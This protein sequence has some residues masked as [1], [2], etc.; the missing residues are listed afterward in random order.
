MC[1]PD[2]RVV[3][4]EKGSQK[5]DLRTLYASFALLAAGLLV[6]SQ[7]KAFHWDEGFHILAARLINLGKRPYLDFFFPQT[8]LNAYWNAAWM[9]IF[10]QSWHVVHAVAALATIGSVILIAQYLFVLFPDRKWKPIVAFAALA[11]FGLN[12]LVWEFGAISQAYPLCLLLT[13]AAFRAAIAAVDR[14][15]FWRSLLTGVLGGSAAASSLLT[16]AVLPVLLIWIWLNNRAGSRW[17]KIAGFTA[18]AATSLTP[19]LILFANG[20]HQTIF[21]IFTYHFIYRRLDWES[22]TGHDIEV[23]TSWINNSPCL[24][25]V[26]LTLAGLVSIKKM[27][28]DRPR[29]SEFRLCLW[30]ALAIGAQNLAAHPTFPQYFIFMMP[31]LTV[32][33]AIGFYAVAVRLGNPDRPR[34][35]VTVMLCIAALCLEHGVYYADVDSYTWRQLERVADK[36]RQVTP[37]DSALFAPEQIYFLVQWPAPSGMEN[38]TAHKL[39]FAPEENERL[40][41]AS[42]EDLDRRIKL[43][44]FATAVVCDDDQ[45]NELRGWNVYSRKADFGDCT[46][47]WEFGKKALQPSQP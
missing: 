6:Y 44:G 15:R 31:F 36:V 10:G 20:S 26:L 16:A 37:K 8:P 24:L 34:T 38:G 42:K 30:L 41:M 47:F 21:N 33:A 12:S 43:G 4:S 25:L 23:V 40:H 17:N 14:P 11:V 32:P 9:K 22:A 18:G 28:F 2:C 5:K 7:T 35:A 1:D 39:H 46:V 27:G 19:V 3:V 29:R 45:A 13:V